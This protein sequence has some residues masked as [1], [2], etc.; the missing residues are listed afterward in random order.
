[1]P[2]GS[3]L[4][5]FGGGAVARKPPAA[6]ASAPVFFLERPAKIHIRYVGDRCEPCEN[7]CKFLLQIVSIVVGPQCRREF[8]NFLHEPHECT[9]DPPFYIFFIVHGA[10]QFLKIAHRD[11]ALAFHN[12]GSLLVRRLPCCV[13]YG[14]GEA[15]DLDECPPKIESDKAN[16]FNYDNQVNPF[17]HGTGRSRDCDSISPELHQPGN[18]VTCGP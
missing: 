12:P 18:D 1:M 17:S 10:N 3:R 13:K 8:P 4:R 7:V 15:T 11:V 9:G 2:G 14:A 16:D 6:R 5:F